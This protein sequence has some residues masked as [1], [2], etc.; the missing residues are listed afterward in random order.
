MKTV[1]LWRNIAKLV[2]FVAISGALTFVFFEYLYVPYVTTE[3]E[4]QIRSI[5]GYIVGVVTTLICLCFFEPCR[6]E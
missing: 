2:V 6:F 4:N 3:V 1:I 5:V